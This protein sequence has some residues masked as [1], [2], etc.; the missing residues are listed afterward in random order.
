MLKAVKVKRYSY[1]LKTMSQTLTRSTRNQAG[2]TL[3]ELLVS[4]AIIGILMGIAIPAIG[5]ALRRGREGAVRTEV[6]ALSQ[7]I[8]AYKLK[9]GD[10]P[11]DFFDWNL[12]VRHYR[13]IFPSIEISELNVLRDQCALQTAVDSNAANPAHDSFR[14]DR[15]EAL[16][17]SLGGFSSDPQ[18]PFTGAGG[19]LTPKGTLVVTA[20]PTHYNNF[21]YNGTRENALFDFKTNLTVGEYD[22]SALTALSTEEAAGSGDLFPT[23]VRDAEGAPYLYFDSRT[24]GSS[25]AS[26]T[27]VNLYNAPAG[28]SWGRTRPYLGSQL[29]SPTESVVRTLPA[30]GSAGLAFMNKN[31]FQIISGGLDDAFGTVTSIPHTAAAP[32]MGDPLYPSFPSGEL[33]RVDLAATLPSGESRSLVI[34]EG[35]KYQ[36]TG[37]SNVGTSENFH[38]DNFAN[39]ATATLDSELP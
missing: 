2:F 23:Y 28:K 39:F 4:I 16:V 8:E 18:H 26:T 1:S 29:V 13:K 30:A 12:V 31:T 33:W 25:V 34:S 11:P 19:P 15:A 35:N 20:R 21:A 6:E 27:I 3:V 5:A 37:L 22:V 7:S 38:N 24:Y 17:W 32:N 10:Y 9:Y 14:I 36:E